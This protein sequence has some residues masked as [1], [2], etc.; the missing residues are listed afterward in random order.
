MQK[1]YQNLI[2]D[3][4]FFGGAADAEDMNKNEGVE[5][6]NDLRGEANEPAYSIISTSGRSCTRSF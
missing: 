6:I 3:K 1:K 4:I 5:V 2:E